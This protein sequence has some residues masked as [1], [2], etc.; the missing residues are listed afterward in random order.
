MHLLDSEKGFN[1]SLHDF[2]VVNC[3]MNL[4]SNWQKE[5]M[6]PK[7]SLLYELLT[8]FL[9]VMEKVVQRIWYMTP[10]SCIVVQKLVTLLEMNLTCHLMF[11]FGC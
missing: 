1:T 4:Q 3:R 11:G 2:L 10:W 9:K 7:K 6:D 5:L 8:S